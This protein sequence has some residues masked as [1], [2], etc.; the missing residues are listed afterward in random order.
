MTK[1]VLMLSLALSASGIH[2]VAPKQEL[3][4]NLAPAKNMKCHETCAKDGCVTVADQGACLNLAVANGH[5]FYSYRSFDRRCST[6]KYCKLTKASSM[7]HAYQ[8]MWKE[9]KLGNYKCHTKCN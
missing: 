7:W 9:V 3:W 4:G 1:A 8:A 5:K 6:S 2:A